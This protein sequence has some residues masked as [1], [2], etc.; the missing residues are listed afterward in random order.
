MYHIK[1][2]TRCLKSAERISGAL[3]GL[4][5]EKSL[6]DIT[7]T[8]IQ[9]ASGTGRSTFYR[10]FDN[11]DDVLLYLAEE[12]F[13][14]MVK[15]YM[16]LSWKAFTGGFI[17]VIV[18]ESRE[19]ANIVASGKAAVVSKALRSE[20]IREA[21]KQHIKFDD[22]SRYMISIFVGGCISMVSAWDENGRKESL[23][24]LTEIMHRTFDYAQIEKTLSRKE[25]GVE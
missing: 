17:A 11:I 16:E 10:L 18:E 15:S 13:R 1:K 14:G 7:V 22:R 8:D 6:A 2:D 4:L 24:E 3:R 9:R 12:E 23:E 5:A 25:E 21:Q 20:L 19:L